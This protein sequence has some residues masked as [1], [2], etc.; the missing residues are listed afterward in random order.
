MLGQSLQTPPLCCAHAHPRQLT[1]LQHYQPLDYP[2][3]HQ[4]AHASQCSIPILLPQSLR[5]TLTH[6]VEQSV[7]SW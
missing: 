1:A 6:R 4:P 3:A 7:F 5:F 2:I